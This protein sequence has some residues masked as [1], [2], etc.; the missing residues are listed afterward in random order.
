MVAAMMSFGRHG[1]R[2]G[3]RPVALKIEAVDTGAMPSKSRANCCEPA[4]TQSHPR[5]PTHPNGAGGSIIGP[6][7]VVHIRRCPQPAS[8]SSMGG[9]PLAAWHPHRRHVHDVPPRPHPRPQHVIN[10]VLI[11]NRRTLLAAR[12]LR[13]DGHRWCVLAWMFDRQRW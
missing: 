1:D 6:R 7:G 9:S 12:D 2:S 5:S 4:T 11:H 13:C 8:T 10:D 3:S